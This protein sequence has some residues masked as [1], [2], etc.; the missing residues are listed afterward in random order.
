MFNVVCPG[1]QRKDDMWVCLDMI[2][3]HKTVILHFAVMNQVC[4]QLCFMSVFVLF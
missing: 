1:C 2:M 3:E 4:S